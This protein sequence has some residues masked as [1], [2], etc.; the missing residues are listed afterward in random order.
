MAALNLLYN[1]LAG[2]IRD[3]ILETTEELLGNDRKENK[4]LVCNNI[5]NLF[6]KP[7]TLKGTKLS[8]SEAARQYRCA[9]R[10]ARMKTKKAKEERI[11]QQY[12][13]TKK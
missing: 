3:A 9:N 10:M 4:P 13:K 2:S 8:R 11:S 6:D 7:K 1:E 12:E 5:L